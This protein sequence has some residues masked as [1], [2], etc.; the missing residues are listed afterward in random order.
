MQVKVQVITI[1]DEG[2][3][4]TREVACMERH[5]LTPV[6]LGLS[7]AEGKALL[8]ALQAVVVEWQMHVYLSQQRPCPHCRHARCSKGVHHTAFRTVFGTL[9]MP[10]PR[11]QHCDCQPH[12]THSFSP[13]AELLPEGPHPSYCSWRASGPPWWPMA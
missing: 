12:E 8:Q 5:D 1:T 6:T 9:S 4:I 2:Q 3:E 10:S 7:L 13:L 11:L